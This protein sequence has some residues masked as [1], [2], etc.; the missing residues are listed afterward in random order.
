MMRLVVGDTV[1]EA[2]VSSNSH[3]SCSYV[4]CYHVS[5]NHVS[6][7]YVSCYHVSCNHVSRN[8][9]SCYHVSCNHVSCSYVSCYHVSCYHVSCYHVSRNHVSCY[10]VSCYHVSCYH[11]SCNHVSCNHVSLGLPLKCIRLESSCV[12]YGLPEQG[13]DERWTVQCRCNIK[14]FA[15]GV[16]HT[17][18][19]KTKTL[20]SCS[21]VSHKTLELSQ[22]LSVR[23]PGKL[24][25]HSAEGGG[26]LLRWSSPYPSSS[27]LNK[28]LNYQVSYRT[29]RQD[30]WTTE[31]VTGTRMKLEAESLV[32]GRRYEAKVRA[33]GEVGL[34][35]EWSPLVTWQTAQAPGQVPSLQCVLD[36]EKEATCSWEVRRDLAHFITYQLA[37][38]HNQTEPSKR[39]CVNVTVSADIGETMLRYSCALAV[40]D[41]AHQLLELVPARNTKAFR[42]H[43]HIRPSQPRN[44][45]VI[46]K[47]GSWIVE[48]TEPDLASKLALSYQ[49][50]YWNTQSQEYTQLQNVSEGSKSLFIPGVSL[51]PSQDY[52]IQ[53]RALVVPGDGPRYEGTPSEWTK[54]A[55]WHTRPYTFMEIVYQSISTVIYTFISVLVVIVFII[56]YCTIP[57][58]HRKVAL[59]VESVP[60]P[61]KSK[62]L[63]EIKSPNSWSSTQSENTSIYK[64]QNLERFSICSFEMSLGPTKVTDNKQQDS[65]SEDWGCW[66]C[67]EPSSHVDTSAMSFSGPYIFCQSASDPC[68][69]SGDVLYEGQEGNI[70]GGPLS[71]PPERLVLPTSGSGQGYV[72]LPSQNLSRSTEEL[73]CCRD[74]DDI[75][76]DRY[77]NGSHGDQDADI[78]LCPNEPEIQPGLSGSTT[79]DG[80]PAYT[81]APSSPW[82]EGGAPEPSGYYVL[83]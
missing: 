49:V 34:W 27:S 18:F 42:A 71:P 30:D 83:P 5:C 25:V 69:E 24:S 68:P 80:P 28:N 33:R 76:T 39:C 26:R 38:R 20:T 36:G 66:D 79:G 41:P 52:S 56:L 53:V 75:S 2:S 82:P 6:C 9:V 14:R 50:R 22:Q 72:R 46:D 47:E 11:V 62:V 43:Q 54:P 60:S 1:P 64:V 35:S 51:A 70:S 4:S 19:F 32:P 31:D 10:H 45:K 12:P 21:L 23:P 17:F 58:C 13:A 48:W 57:A 7:S 59:W 65:M 63:S 16:D 15:I 81:L 77:E 37:C 78:T 73:V 3:V 8:H 44:L 55:E 67:D 40:S 29:E 61:D 74:D